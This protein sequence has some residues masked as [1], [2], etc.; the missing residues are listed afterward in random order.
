MASIGVDVLHRLTQSERELRFSFKHQVLS[1]QDE[2]MA[3]HMWLAP[4]CKLVFGRCG[5]LSAPGCG[6]RMV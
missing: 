1:S 5:G 2:A 4:F 3:K 6:L